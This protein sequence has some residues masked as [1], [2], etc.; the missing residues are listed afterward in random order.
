M[1]R[2]SRQSPP[3]GAY[4]ED[5]IVSVL[6]GAMP[7]GVA[8]RDAEEFPFPVDPLQPWVLAAVHLSHQPRLESHAAGRRGGPGG[9]LVHGKGVCG[10]KRGSLVIRRLA[11][12]RSHQQKDGVLEYTGVQ[13]RDSMAFLF[14]PALGASVSHLPGCSQPIP[15]SNH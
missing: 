5:G 11:D 14:L 9:R 8:P 10:R 4:L 12:R 3:P 7:R 6:A 13:A 1:P 2:K 15:F